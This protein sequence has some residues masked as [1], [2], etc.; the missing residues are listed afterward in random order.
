MDNKLL[1]AER[2]L[3]RELNESGDKLFGQL[4]ANGITAEHFFSVQH[5][6][7]WRAAEK[8]NGVMDVPTIVS[9]VTD[10]EALKK[11]K[12]FGTPKSIVTDTLFSGEALQ[13]ATIDDILMVIRDAYF[14]REIVRMQSDLWKKM[15]AATTEDDRI[16]AVKGFQDGLLDLVHK[17]ASESGKINSLHGGLF[18]ELVQGTL[19][20]AKIP[21]VIPT[22]LSQLDYYL[23]GG[24]HVGDCHALIMPTS[25]GKTATMVGMA[26]SAVDHGAVALYLT[27]ETREEEV[28]YRFLSH[29]SGIKFNHIRHNSFS[30]Q[31]EIEAFVRA[32]N[33]LSSSDLLH[34]FLPLRKDVATVQSMVRKLKAQ[35][36]GKKIAV[37][38]D[39]VGKM[40]P[41]PTK[42]RPDEAWKALVVAL[43]DIAMYENVAVVLAGQ[44]GRGV[45]ERATKMP[46]VNDA[47]ETAEME[48]T[49][50]V[51]ITAYRP[52][53]YDQTF[54][55]NEIHMA[56]PKN[57]NGEVSTGHFILE[58]VPELMMVRD[59]TPANTGSVGWYDSDF[60]MGDDDYDEGEGV[61][62]ICI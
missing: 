44:V 30:D 45:S 20:G 40:S 23:N 42:G 35:Y 55:A 32:G 48:N 15:N 14:E 58:W 9:Y 11:S 22:G 59:P 60:V 61:A 33:Y 39:Y 6:A 56:V 31:R 3:F 19:S 46:T 62:A 51:L 2:A 43:G 29:K 53:L 34:V 17:S 1:A 47:R 50:A 21:V 54:P 41:P 57:R 25:H 13:G 27:I 49:P 38:I 7:M 12:A 28:A 37:F 52:Y 4:S 16:N 18:N 24:L 8:T 36:P 26:G 10:D 5:Q